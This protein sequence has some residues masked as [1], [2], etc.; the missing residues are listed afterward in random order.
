MLYEHL[1]RLAA[2]T[3]VFTCMPG[4]LTMVTSSES[5]IDDLVLGRC[6]HFNT[7]LGTSCVMQLLAPS[8]C[9]VMQACFKVTIMGSDPI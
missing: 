6:M 2:M 5:D 7:D 1:V 8:L 3:C 4:M 9:P